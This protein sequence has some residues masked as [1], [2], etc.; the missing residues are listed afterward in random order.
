MAIIS[1]FLADRLGIALGD[2]PALDRFNDAARALVLARGPIHTA[3]LVTVLASHVAALA[4]IVAGPIA[5]PTDVFTEL[6]RGRV[7]LARQQRTVQRR[8][9]E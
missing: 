4:G 5:D 2:D 7:A 3:D 9:F 1:P 8:A 6:I